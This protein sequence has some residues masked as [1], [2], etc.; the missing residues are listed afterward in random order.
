M[1][2]NFGGF[3]GDVEV[4]FEKIFS[5]LFCLFCSQSQDKPRY[6]KSLKPLDFAGFIHPLSKSTE[7]SNSPNFFGFFRGIVILQRENKP[8]DTIIASHI[9]ATYM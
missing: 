4:F 8:F 7:N 2:E 1:G 6:N 3:K 5:V 9:C